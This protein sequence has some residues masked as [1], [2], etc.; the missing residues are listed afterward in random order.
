LGTFIKACV[1]PL[2]AAVLMGCSA[3]TSGA[4]VAEPIAPPSRA[5]SLAE[6]D[7]CA[8]VTDRI[9]VEVGILD[10]G[11]GRPDDL[12]GSRGCKWHVHNERFTR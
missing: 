5:A 9:A 8:L 12:A 6:V 4:P 1:L 7:P 11:A 3:Q 10:V 2:L